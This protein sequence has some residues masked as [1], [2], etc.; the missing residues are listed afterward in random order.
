M[1]R[2]DELEFCSCHCPYHGEPNGCNRPEGECQAYRQY[3]ELK[4]FEE[5]KD[6]IKLPCKIRSTNERCFNFQIVYR[7]IGG[8]IRTNE[9]DDEPEA[10]AFITQ[11]KKDK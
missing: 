1:H 11:L 9:F 5:S 10:D 2:L 3:L 7:D 8:F 6:M 4:D